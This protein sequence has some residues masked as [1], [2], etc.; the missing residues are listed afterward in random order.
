LCLLSSS[1]TEFDNDDDDDDDDVGN[2]VWF[3]A[4]LEER[5]AEEKK[6]EGEKRGLSCDRISRTPSKRL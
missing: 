5:E 1:L 6:G 4:D 2:R 3:T